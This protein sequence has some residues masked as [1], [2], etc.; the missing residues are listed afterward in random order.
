LTNESSKARRVPKVNNTIKAMNAIYGLVITNPEGSSRFERAEALGD[1]INVGDGGREEEEDKRGEAMGDD[2]L[3]GDI[4]VE[5][6]DF[7]S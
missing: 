4:A 6:T 3:E 2:G 1:V 5:F 7:I